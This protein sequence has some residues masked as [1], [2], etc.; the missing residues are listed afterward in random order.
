MTT[1]RTRRALIAGGLVALLVAAPRPAHAYLLTSL[2]NSSGQLSPG[3][4]AQ[5]PTYY[6]T[7]QGTTGI[8]VPAL[9]AAVRG[10]FSAW[11]SVPTAHVSVIYGGLTTA[12]PDVVDYQ[13]T[14][15]FA[16]LGNIPGFENTLGFTDYLLL[17]DGTP[18]HFFETDIVLNSAFPWSTD[19]NGVAGRFDLQSIATHEI[20]HFLGLNH[21]AIGVVTTAADGS[22]DV[23]AKRAVMFPIA[24]TPGNVSDRTLT[25]DDI[26]G[27]S[28]LYP[29]A[30]FQQSTGTISGQVTKNG[31]GVFGAQVLALDTQTGALVASFSLDT[32]GDYTIAGLAPGTYIVRAE[33][34]DTLD[35][36]S[37]FNAT[38]PVD[39][40][41][42]VAYHLG[43]VAVP[44]GANAGGINISVVAK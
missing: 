39:T 28:V 8:S 38:D 41:F 12:E 6:I 20:G 3:T 18:A 15:G 34:L 9:V 5:P 22:L 35:V 2:Q 17:A 13:N 31:A 1:S 19:P 4:W 16:D 23:Q 26:A 32:H 25:P 43:P 44:R 37:F 14:I 40:N 21:S 24:F 27:I 29:A 33:P 36:T 7:N 11:T 42:Q 30:G 10:G